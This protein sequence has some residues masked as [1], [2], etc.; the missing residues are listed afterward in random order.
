MDP[1]VLINRAREQCSRGQQIS[2]V[3]SLCF[4]REMA[5]MLA[6]ANPEF[7]MDDAIDVVSEWMLRAGRDV[8]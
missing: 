3:C 4:Q 5:Q 8:H 6:E 2:A 7:C 1:E